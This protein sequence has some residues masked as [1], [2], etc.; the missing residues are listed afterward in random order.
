MAEER[1]V[2]KDGTIVIREPKKSIQDM[3]GTAASKEILAAI[4]EL[5]RYIR[6]MLGRGEIERGVFFTFQ[7][8]V[9]FWK[10]LV[11]KA[12]R[13][14]LRIKKTELDVDSTIDLIWAVLEELGAQEIDKFLKKVGAEFIMVPSHK[15]WVLVRDGE[16]FVKAGYNPEI[17]EE[18]VDRVAEKIGELH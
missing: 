12:V 13:E 4:Q 11:D 10:G 1:I 7:H 15:E 3:L 8:C 18:M 14:V 16:E 5:K 2:T 9:A 6:S 17:I